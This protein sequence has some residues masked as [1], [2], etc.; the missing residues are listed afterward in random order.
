MCKGDYARDPA[1]YDH[2]SMSDHEPLTTY[3]LRP[4]S[5]RQVQHTFAWRATVIMLALLSLVWGCVGRDAV[6]PRGIEQVR[7]VIVIY[8]ENWSFDGQFGLFPGANGIAN[9][10][11]TIRQVRKDGS[12]YTSLPQP[13]FQ[14]QPDTRIPAGLPVRPFD[15]LR[16]VPRDQRANDLVRALAF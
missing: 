13:L 9:A 12:P 2:P 5:G 14:R 10:G 8:M 6:A 7:H 15:L 16:Y 3:R 11:D 1:L 4:I